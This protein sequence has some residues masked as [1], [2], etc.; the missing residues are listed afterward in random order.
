M[1]IKTWFHC[2]YRAIYPNEAVEGVVSTADDMVKW[3]HYHLLNVGNMSQI[4]E[5]Q[6]LEQTYLPQVQYKLSKMTEFE[7]QS[8]VK[9]VVFAH[10]LGWESG[11]YR[12]RL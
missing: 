3:L 10:N 1:R 12:S 9:Q 8:R 5:G 11:E 4:Q 7:P 2:F 6:V